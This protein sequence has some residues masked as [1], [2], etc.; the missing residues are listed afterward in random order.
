MEIR[1]KTKRE[2]V[3]ARMHR[4]DSSLPFKVTTS[5]QTQKRENFI[6]VEKVL[7]SLYRKYKLI[8]Y[9]SG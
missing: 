4:Y 2:S 8:K 1:D 5:I 7:F 3:H 6:S 9:A